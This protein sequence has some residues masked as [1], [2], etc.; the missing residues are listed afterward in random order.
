MSDLSRFLRAVKVLEKLSWKYRHEAWIEA[1]GRYASIKDE[2]RIWSVGEL[3][4]D[5]GRELADLRGKPHC[6]QCGNDINDKRGD[7]EEDARTDARY[8]SAKCRQ[9]AYRK[10]VTA[11]TPNAR[12]AITNPAFCDGS[13]RVA[14]PIRNTVGAP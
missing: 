7:D 14:E 12:I 3:L 11:R 1:L 2:H 13:P 4:D 5:I 8:C 9:R 6:R 10:R